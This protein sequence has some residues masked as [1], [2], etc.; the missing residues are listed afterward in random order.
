M[1]GSITEDTK[2]ATEGTKGADGTHGAN[3][4]YEVVTGWLDAAYDVFG[5]P[6]VVRRTVMTPIHLADRERAARRGACLARLHGARCWWHQVKPSSSGKT[7][8]LEV[9]LF[10]EGR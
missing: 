7:S 10:G 8:I 2:G 1:G 4:A 5:R 3:G 9:W 6:R